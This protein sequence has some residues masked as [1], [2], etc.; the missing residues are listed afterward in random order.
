MKTTIK[1]IGLI[2]LISAF[3]ACSKEKEVLTP[4]KP[5]YDYIDAHMGTTG[6]ELSTSNQITFIFGGENYM[7]DSDS[8][9]VNVTL[10]GV[11]IYAHP[12]TRSTRTN[13]YIK[14]LAY[15]YLNVTELN[16]VFILKNPE[17]ELVL[18]KDYLPGIY[19]EVY[20]F[21]EYV[22]DFEILNRN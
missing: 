9:K 5:L 17:I 3:T 8:F 11:N 20:Y 1:I 7:N 6:A 13:G 16:D 14:P 10:Q 15:T 18:Y 22:E 19:F 4:N 21:G 12:Y 2:A